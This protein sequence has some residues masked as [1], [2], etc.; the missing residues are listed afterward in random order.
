MIIL[1]T[2]VLSS[3]VSDAPDAK[4]V[5]WLDAQSADEIYT[6]TITYFESWAGIIRLDPSKRRSVLVAAFAA[7]ME[8]MLYGRILSF[9][10]KCANASAELA[11]TRRRAGRPIEP[12]DTFI[13]GIAIVHGAVIATGN[14]RHFTDANVP[15]INPWEAQ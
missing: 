9:D 7:A 3:I 14:I 11:A 13:A 8:N 1:D 12:R 4:I 10:Q 6:T 5:D 15:L 2:N